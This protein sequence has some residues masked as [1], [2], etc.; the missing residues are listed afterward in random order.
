MRDSEELNSWLAAQALDRPVAID[1]ETVY[2]RLGQYG[3]ELG[4]Y[5]W[6]GAVPARLQEALKQGFSSALVF[7]AGLALAPDGEGVL[8]SQW[9]PEARGWVDAADALERLLNQLALWRAALAP[10]GRE[11]R[12]APAGAG[13][14]EQKMRRLLAGA[15]GLR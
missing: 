7:D 1:G 9:L 5:L 2:L 10:S 14:D 13:R 6:P 15:G 4:A 3:A 12:A 11:V 8:L